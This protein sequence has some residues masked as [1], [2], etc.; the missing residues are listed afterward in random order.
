MNWERYRTVM[1]R[2]AIKTD[3]MATEDA[4]FMS[5]HMPFSALELFQ[6]GYYEKNKM[7]AA[8][9][10]LTEDEVFE[11]LIYN[12]TDEDRMIIVRGNH[13]TGKSHL[14]RYL[15]G[16]FE[17]SPATI[18]NPA[19]EQLVF[20][21]RLNNSVRGA[22]AQLLEQNA[23][24][25]PEIADK[26]RRFVASSESKDELSFKNE[27]LYAYIAAVRSDTSGAPYRA[28]ICRDIASYLS[29]S[30]VSEHLL[31]EGGAIARCYNIIT[32]PSNE[33]L[34]D[35]TIFTDEDINVKKI[36]NEVR[37]QGDPQAASFAGM[38]KGDAEAI[39]KLISYLNSFTRSVIQRC[40]D[41][42]SENAETIFAQLR[43]DLKKQGKSLTIFIEDFTGFTGID[44]EL[45]TA[46]SYES[47]GEYADLCRVTAVIG[48]T[49][50]YYYEFRGNF[51]DRVTYQIEVTERSYGTDDFIVQMAGRYL[52]AIY[53]EPSE[54][55]SWIESGAELSELPVSDFVAPCSWE[56]ITIAGREATLYPFNRRALLALYEALAI[57][58]PRKFLKDV[59]RAQLKEYFDGKIY[60]DEWNFPLNPTNIQMTNAPHSSAIDRLE[61]LS[62][63]DKERLKAVLAIW[64]DG[65]ATGI[66]ESDGAHYFGSV[67]EE[68]ISDIALGEFSGIGQ[69]VDKST[70]ATEPV[71]VAHT[72]SEAP[73]ITEP[74]TPERTERKEP[75][76]TKA[77]IDGATKDY[78]KKKNDI[79]SWFAGEKLKYDIDYRG[80]LRTMVRGDARQCGAINWQDSG[81]PAYIADR[82]LEDLGVY[83]IE[84]QSN[85]VNTERAIVYLDRSAESRDVLMALNERNYAKGWDFEGSA[86]YQQRLITWLERNKSE[87]IAKVTARKKGEAPL[88]ILEWC[89][90]LQYLKACIL[91]QRIDTSSPYSVVRSL[92]TE[93]KP[94]DSIQRDTSA[95]QDLLRFVK[96]N[97]A[98]FAT[99]LKLLQ[100]SAATTVGAVHFAASPSSNSCYRSNE[101]IVAAENLMK[102]SWDIEAELPVDI[103]PNHLLYNPASLLRK[104]YPK[105]K[106]VMAAET[107][108]VAAVIDGLEGY[109]GEL[110]K[111]NLLTALAAIQ[112]LFRVFAMNG[113]LGS[114]DLKTKYEKAPVKIAELVCA[115]VSKLREAT[116]LPA[117]QRLAVYASNSL[118]SL[119]E[120]LRD[121]R[122]IAER[123]EKE[124]TRANSEVA[125]LGD[126]SAS[127]G[128]AQAAIDA[129]DK[130]CTQLEGLEV[131]ENA[132]N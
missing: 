4:Y 127:D 122:A 114:N 64:G 25:A 51:K 43:R 6:G 53:C 81:V 109:I 129:L 132:T 61:N 101:L 18:Y 120:V 28:V 15:K 58:T 52:N 33:I 86:Y 69:T 23:I 40:A 92:C 94:D 47:G 130:L 31:R 8:T 41:I 34:Q 11:Q 70:V 63:A 68:F 119:Y 48:I 22:F 65:S 10:L 96:N 112:E 42:S 100:Q 113:I 67:R 2:H 110:T 79:I 91:G 116:N 5:T 36:I 35:T 46:L 37:R 82:R 62:D 49:N 83:I 73:A 117:V 128:R 75:P 30:R 59:I 44:Q 103:L 38:I 105:I 118:H 39:E 1:E 55:Q 131:V 24:T 111:E 72:T 106:T 57:K 29:D 108:A 84:D 90:A 14:I 3:D 16:K 66:K 126:F 20:L 19:T 80:W 50:D 27:I 85:Q 95:W 13:G 102:A 125:K 99:A 98:E 104:V 115:H 78:Q 76:Q 54:L 124:A 93:F 77:H 56:H 97:D 89:L 121:M 107:A 71:P 88:P 17:Q 123:A 7:P 26:I 9:E 21:R 74:K 32:A 87:I 45:I 12:P 60:G